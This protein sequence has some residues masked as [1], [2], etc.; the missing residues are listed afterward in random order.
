MLL[1]FISFLVLDCHAEMF[2]GQ[3]VDGTLHWSVMVVAG[4]TVIISRDVNILLDNVFL[5]GSMLH[6]L[7]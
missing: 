4:L 1:W 5:F 6:Y 3:M 2:V 7:Y